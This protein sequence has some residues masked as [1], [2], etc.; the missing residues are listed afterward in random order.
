[1]RT[2]I[3][4]INFD[5]VTFNSAVEHAL[6]LTEFSS[7]C[8][9]ANPEIVLMARRDPEFHAAV[10]GAN[11]VVADGIGVI[12]ASRLLGRLLPAKIAGIELA[13]RLIARLAESRDPRGVFLFGAKPGVA[14]LAAMHLSQRYPGLTIAGFHSG[15][16]YDERQISQT[17]ANSNAALVL[18]CLGARRQ[19]TFMARHTARFG[20]NPALLIG[21]GGS[22]DIFAGLVPRAPLTWRKLGLEWLYRLIRQPSRITRIAKLP[23]ILLLALKERI[24]PRC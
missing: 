18:V 3:L 10:N 15:Y 12:Y 24:F 16:A 6:R 1:M 5:A 9:T 11:L 20:A 4:G 17:I 19:E 7:Y 8:V 23:L 2:D 22:L 21:L 13:E 14:E